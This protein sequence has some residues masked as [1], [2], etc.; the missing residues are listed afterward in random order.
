[1]SLVFRI[2]SNLS[3]HS[4]IDFFQQGSNMTVNTFT[5]GWHTT[6][7][8]TI[9]HQRTNME[10]AFVE[11]FLPAHEFGDLIDIGCGPARLAEALGNADYSIVGIDTD[12]PSIVLAREKNV[13]NAEFHTLDMRELSALKRK[14]DGAINLWHSFGY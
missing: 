1:M 7:L 4:P 2:R 12:A 5:P 11:R 9:P 8:D 10:I 13:P 6:F 14:F 3:V